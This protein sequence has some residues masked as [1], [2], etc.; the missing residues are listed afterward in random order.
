M[1]TTRTVSTLLALGATAV[2]TAAAPVALAAPDSGSAGGS[3]SSGCGPR[4][5]SDRRFLRES[6]QTD[7]SC[8]VQDSAIELAQAECRW[9]DVYGNSIHNQI[10]LA[11]KTRGS[12]DYPYLFLDAA[13]NAYCPRHRL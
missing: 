4:T 12:V 2:L 7:E 10:V 13:I 5:N 3:S 8:G 6:Y 9:L 11:E 1:R